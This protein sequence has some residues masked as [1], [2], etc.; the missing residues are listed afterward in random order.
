MVFISKLGDVRRSSPTTP[1]KELVREA[2]QVLHEAQ[3]AEAD[4]LAFSEYLR[5]LFAVKKLGSW[6]E[7][8]DEAENEMVAAV[9]QVRHCT[10][11]ASPPPPSLPLPSHSLLLPNSRVVPHRPTCHPRQ[12]RRR[13]CGLM[14]S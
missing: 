11:A 2:M 9:N 4:H 5:D 3:L 14:T 8:A 6:M 7:E 12:R 13:A 1:E 10:L